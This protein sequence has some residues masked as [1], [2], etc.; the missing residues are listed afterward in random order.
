MCIESTAARKAY[1]VYNYIRYK[2]NPIHHM[3]ISVVGYGDL[4]QQ[5]PVLG[6]FVDA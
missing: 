2:N 5:C 4:G 3:Q 6:L 1:Q